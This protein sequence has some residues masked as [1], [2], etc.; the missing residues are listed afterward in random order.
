MCAQLTN[1]PPRKKRFT[2][3]VGMPSVRPV[4]PSLSTYDT[5]Q[6]GAPTSKWECTR[7]GGA[8][9]Q[10][11]L[12]LADSVHPAGHP[13]GHGEGETRLHIGNLLDDTGRGRRAVHEGTAAAQRPM[14]RAAATKHSHGP[15]TR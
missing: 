11:F 4:Y 6:Q 13:F 10:H 2:T 8:R 9:K 14:G 12:F 5:P 7:P 3:D 15:T 1:S